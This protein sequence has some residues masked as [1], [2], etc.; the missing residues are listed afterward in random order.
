MDRRIEPVIPDLFAVTLKKLGIEAAGRERPGLEETMVQSLGVLDGLLTEEE[1]GQ[2]RKELE[3]V[4]EVRE[5]RLAEGEYE[6]GWLERQRMDTYNNLLDELTQRYLGWYEESEQEE[7][8]SPGDDEAETTETTETPSETEDGG[9]EKTEEIPL[10]DFT[11][12]NGAALT[13]QIYYEDW[14]D[15]GFEQKDAES[16]WEFVQSVLPE[17]ALKEFE[18]F[19]LFS[20]GEYGTLAYVYWDANQP[21]SAHWGMALDMA[22]LEDTAELILT[23]IHEYCHYLTLKEGQA[24]NTDNP[25]VVTYCEESLETLKDSYLNEFYWRFWGFLADE[26]RSGADQELFYLRHANLFCTEY[27]VTDPSEDIA[28]SFSYYVV[29]SEEERQ[30]MPEPLREKL[31]YFEE[32]P[33]FSQFRQEVREKLGMKET[34]GWWEDAA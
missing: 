6:M 14:K 33:L 10:A 16:V 12:E 17:G 18:K 13:D 21:V 32:I 28:E 2:V 20:D 22:D 30:N 3:R 34:D 5:K 27:A 4:W 26:R 31:N 24:L 7:G 11:I 29:L 1:R 9:Y 8:L 15:A 19:Y 23:V 25:G